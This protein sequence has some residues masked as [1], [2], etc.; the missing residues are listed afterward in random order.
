MAL[1]KK[2]KT[3][4]IEFLENYKAPQ[5]RNV[6]TL[7]LLISLYSGMRMVEVNALKPEN[8]DFEKL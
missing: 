3:R 8:I 4:F 6:Y 5:G 1:I 2:E 7:Q